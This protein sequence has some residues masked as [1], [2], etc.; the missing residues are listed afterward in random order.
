MVCVLIHSQ[1]KA[2]RTASHPH[3]WTDNK[4][5]RIIKG[6]GRKLTCLYNGL[7]YPFNF[8][9]LLTV[10]GVSPLLLAT[11][12]WSREKG[13]FIAQLPF[14]CAH[15][16]SLAY[17]S[18]IG[19]TQSTTLPA[20]SLLNRI[21]GYLW[22][23]NHR[24]D[25][26]SDGRNPFYCRPLTESWHRCTTTDRPKSVGVDRQTTPLRTRLNWVI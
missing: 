18:E 8:L 11:H 15:T 17:Y 26:A 13:E 4:E 25:P 20:L 19:A 21:D 6:I 9:L 16:I 5:G 7:F 3:R 24:A 10:G 12:R 23:Q 1:V 14:F 22:L 2:R